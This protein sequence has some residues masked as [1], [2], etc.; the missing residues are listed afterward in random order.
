[1]SS[2]TRARATDPEGRAGRITLTPAVCR[3]QE[4]PG[5]T[6]SV[7]RFRHLLSFGCALFLVACGGGGGGGGAS[8]DGPIGTISSIQIRWSAVPGV[9]GYR[10]HWGG[11]SAEYTSSLDL[12]LPADDV[13]VL[14][15]MLD[16]LAAPGRYYFVMTAYDGEGQTSPFSNE[17]AVDVD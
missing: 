4:S 6:P 13:G 8:S 7:V 17:I 2:S 9:A 5:S 3:A 11:R 14:T 10:V 15:Y 12:G 16:G 1:M